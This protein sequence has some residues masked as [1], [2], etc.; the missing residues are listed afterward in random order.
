MQRLIFCWFRKH[1]IGFSHSLEFFSI[2]DGVWKVYVCLYPVYNT[3]VQ[4]STVLYSRVPALWCS[5]FNILWLPILMPVFWNFVIVAGEPGCLHLPGKSASLTLCLLCRSLS[6]QSCCLSLSEVDT[7]L[8][9]AV[10]LLVFHTFLER[11]RHFTL[12][13]VSIVE[14]DWRNKLQC[15]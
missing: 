8:C 7:L 12:K 2:K 6:A 1:L 10:L 11:N 14:W 4:S 5:V 13:V 3:R 9:I 15:F